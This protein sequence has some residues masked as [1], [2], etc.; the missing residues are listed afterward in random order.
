ML[1]LEL[2]ELIELIEQLDQL[3]QLEI[4]GNIRGVRCERWE[5]LGVS[6]WVRSEWVCEREAWGVERLERIE[7]Y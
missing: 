2:I 4:I 1:K 6:E 7:Y 5:R 3:D